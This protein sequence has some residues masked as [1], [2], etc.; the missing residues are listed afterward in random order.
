MILISPEANY[1]VNGVAR[2]IRALYEWPTN[3]TK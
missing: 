3:W 1:E 2:S